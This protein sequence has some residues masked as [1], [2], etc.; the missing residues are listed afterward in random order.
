[1]SKLNKAIT[2]LI[3]VTMLVVLLAPAKMVWSGV[4]NQGTTYKGIIIKYK[5]DT[6]SETVK[7]NVKKKLKLKDLKSKKKLKKGKVEVVEVDEGADVTSIVNELRKDT[8]VLYAQP[9]YKLFL[10]YIPDEPDFSAQWG[11]NNTNTQGVD[12]GVTDAWDITKGSTDIIVGVLDTGIDISHDDL[13]KNIYVNKKEIAG[14]GKDDDQNGYIDD[15]NGWNFVSKNG[16]VFDSTI[17]DIHGTHVAGII[18]ASENKMGTIGVS[19]KVKLLPLKFINGDSGYTS[20]AIQAIEYAKAAGAKIINC[21]WGG[22]DENEVLKDEIRNNP[23]ILFIAAAGNGGKLGCAYPG[24]FNL[25]NVVSVGAVDRD[26]KL[27]AFSN[28]GPKVKLAAPG[29]NIL[30]T[31][32]GNNYGTLNGTSMSAPFV[33]G[34]S[35]LL[36]SQNKNLKP[37]EIAAML[38]NGSIEQRSLKGKIASGGIVNALSTLNSTTENKDESQQQDEQN[39]DTED[40]S[41]VEALA[42][43]QPLL[44][45]QIHF[46]KEGVY[47]PSGNFSDSYTDLAG[48]F[49]PFGE[50]KVTRTYNSLDGGYNLFGYGWSMGYY[51]RIEF[52]NSGSVLVAKVGGKSYAFLK[53]SYTGTFN[54]Y[55][56][57]CKMETQGETNNYTAYILTAQD[58]TKY[59]YDSYGFLS[60]IED[61]YGNRISFAN[62]STSNGYRI[63][64][65]YNSLGIEILITYNA[66]G[67][68]DTISDPMG[69]TVKY[70]YDSNSR[71]TCITNPMGNKT[72]YSY[73]TLNYYLSEIRNN[74]GD[75]LNKIEYDTSNRVCKITDAVKNTY[76][77]TYDPTNKK[78][79]VVDSNQNRYIYGYNDDK[80]IT[81]I[82]DPE[83]KNSGNEYNSYG[84]V[85]SATDRNGNITKYDRDVNGNITKI[86]N[87]DGSTK[88]CEYDDKNNLTKEV[89]EKGNT[90]YYF[91]TDK[92]YLAKKVQPM[93]STGLYSETGDQSRFAITTYT[94]NGYGQITS[95]KDPEGNVTTYDYDSKGYLISETS[96]EGNVTKYTNNPIGW[97]TKIIS[98]KGYSIDYTFDNN[99]AIIK[100]AASTGETRR[101][102]YNAAGR[103]VR[104]ISPNLY[105]P[106]NEDTTTNTYN[107]GEGSYITY[108][109]SGLVKSITDAENNT[110]SYTYDLYGQIET[111]SKGDGSVVKYEY[112]KLNRLYKVYFVSKRGATPILLREY[113]YEVLSDKN[114]KRTEKVYFNDKET[115]ETV[116]ILDYRNNVVEK[117]DAEGAATSTQYYSNG[118]ISSTKDEMGY[119]TYYRYDGIGRL[120]EKWSPF[121]EVKGTVYYSYTSI[122]YDKAGR[123]T[124]QR[125]SSEK[126][127]LYKVPGKIT[128]T[129]FTYDK[130]GNKKSQHTDSGRRT[131]F[132]YDADG[133]VNRET[134]YVDKT[135][136]ITTIYE[137]NQFGKT[138]KQKEYIEKRDLA[139]NDTGLK[140]DLQELVTSYEYDKEGNVVSVSKPDGT[141]NDYVHDKLGRQTS[142]VIYEVDEAGNEIIETTSTTYDFEGKKIS[143]TDANGYTTKYQYNRMG[144]LEKVIDPA[145]GIAA[146]YYDRAGRKT[147]EVSPANYYS[148]KAL[149][150]LNR[151]EYA[152]DK[153]GRIITKS[154]IYKNPVSGK[155]EKVVSKAYKYDS[156]GN[157]IKEVD[158]LGYLAG[159]GSTVDERIDKGYGTEYSYNAAGLK[160]S[161]LDPVS[162]ERE[163]DSTTKWE[164]DAKGQII[165]EISTDGAKDSNEYD[166]DGNIIFQKHTSPKTG[167]VSIIKSNTYDYL[168]NLLT[169]KDAKGNTTYY[170]YNNFG[171]KR[172]AKLPGDESIPSMEVYYQYDKQG[173]LS[174]EIYANSKVIIHK[175]NNKSLEVATTEQKLDESQAI[176]VSSVY[177]ANGN[178][179]IEKDGNGNEK[180]K[181]Y[182]ALNRL[183]SEKTIV[184]DVNRK[185]ITKITSYTYDKNGNQT[186][187]KDWKGN[188]LT[189]EYDPLNRLIK[190]TDQN[191]KVIESLYYYANSIQSKSTDALG[192]STSFWY[193]KNNR[194]V[195]KV[196][197][198]K[199]TTLQS[200]DN[201]GNI[202]SKTDGRGNVTKY[203]YDDFNRL[204]QVRNA[205]D[206]LT[207]YSYDANGNMTSIKDGKGNVETYEYNVANKIKRRID[208]GGKTGAVYNKAKT[209]VYTY[210]CYG[211]KA[212]VVDRNGIK[213][214][215]YYDIHGRL[216]KK[217][218]GKVFEENTLNQS[219]EKLTL[220]NVEVAFVE[221]SYDDNGNILTIEGAT[222]ITTRTY[223]EENRVTTK[224]VPQLGTS[225]YQYDATGK[226][227]PK[228]CHAEITTDPKGNVTCKT[229][230]KVGRLSAVTTGTQTTN[231]AY[232]DNGNRK[233]VTYP[234]GST[235]VYTY[236]GNNQIEALSNYRMS[237]GV[238]VLMD[239]YK[240]TYDKAGNQV[241]KN[242]IVNGVNKGVTAYTYDKLNR[243]ESVTDP[244]GKTIAYTFDAVGNRTTETVTITGTKTV[245]TY[246]Y[247]SENRLLTVR[248]KIND[249]ETA[250]VKYVYDGNGNMVSRSNVILD[251]NSTGDGSIS[252][253][254][255]GE[256]DNSTTYYE[257]DNFN[258]LVKVE[259][260]SKTQYYN[261]NGEGYRVEK[262]VAGKTTR[263]LYEGDKVVLEVDDDGL[264]TAR[265]VYG[266]NLLMRTIGSTTVY[267]MYN[268]HGD[269]TALLDASSSKIKA[270][271]SYDE[272]GNLKDNSKVD[273]E[274]EKDGNKDGKDDNWLY[275]A[276]ITAALVTNPAISGGKA[277]QIKTTASTASV[278]KTYATVAGHKYLFAGSYYIAS[279]GSSLST[280]VNSE[281]NSWNLNLGSVY[282]SSTLN[283][284]KEAGV[285]FTAT[286]TTTSLIPCFVDTQTCE[287]YIDKWKLIDLTELYGAG[288]E[289]TTVAAAMTDFDN[290]IMYAGYQYDKETG[291][292]YLNARMYDPTIARFLQEDTYTGEID[293][294]LSLNL[295]T[296]CY[297]EPIK[298]D[299]P[300][301]HFVR[302]TDNDR[303]EY[304][305]ENYGKNMSE[306]DVA[307]FDREGILHFDETKITDSFRETT[308][309]KQTVDSENNYK[310]RK[311]EKGTWVT[312][313][314]DAQKYQLD[315]ES[316]LYFL[317]HFA[318]VQAN[319]FRER[320][321]SYLR[322]ETKQNP[323]AYSDAEAYR[324]IANYSVKLNEAIINSDDQYKVGQVLDDLL[325]TIGSSKYSI[326]KNKYP[327][328]FLKN[329]DSKFQLGL[330]SFGQVGFSPDLQENFAND[331]DPNN[332]QHNLLAIYLGYNYKNLAYFP[333]AFHETIQPIFSG[334]QVSGTF[335][336]WESSVRGINLGKRLANNVPDKYK[337]YGAYTGGS[338]LPSGEKAKM[339]NL[340]NE[341]Y[342]I[343]TWV[344]PPPPSPKPAPAPIVTPKPK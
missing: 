112:D 343:I 4:G 34:I 216:V 65:I 157:V 70:Q 128:G 239:S 181:K 59:R 85:Y 279:K 200:Y 310:Y 3:L 246:S 38:S 206:E 213:T 158:A 198:L 91:Y 94:Y 36:K 80:Y 169:A 227:I 57:H 329:G 182:D 120:T 137:N 116:E 218:A 82:Q 222:G 230:D 183:I 68:I 163:L 241:T 247:N 207:S 253:A 144:L 295:Y 315:R 61:K 16:T 56:N 149:T 122:E 92:R 313:K 303:K 129:Y 293:D 338:S 344:K 142:T 42:T 271:Y 290:S 220:S 186:S 261:Y 100:E 323:T 252:A 214:S 156:R 278:Y 143:S 280:R 251:S 87:P 263:Y 90:T 109:P 31:I 119:S 285:V 39:E 141:K 67:Y 19:P 277:Q 89:D 240:Y 162:K 136:K 254:I 195:K 88:T 48:I 238:K 72:Y 316:R 327:N 289:P 341:I 159:T 262:T 93:S 130:D 229:F 320:M 25:S 197:S 133:N 178:K 237:G 44:T 161:V 27:A 309:Y 58:Q 256:N 211:N 123:V 311:D 266:T 308:L 265:N 177:D 135:N 75:S 55:G 324:K 11:L 64:K 43:A 179:V 302:V 283:Q 47:P 342:K 260:G 108:Y 62:S 212:S 106:E 270:A 5:D 150:D 2:R 20:D 52:Q 326:S 300:S 154:D 201:E 208:H 22:P 321:P 15:V 196:D 33:T 219:G 121:E 1:M 294:P 83:D 46:G 21:S 269:V 9:D 192:N 147:A 167:V 187:I 35:V 7:A 69:R 334:N 305:K 99:G 292:Y 86:T 140:E 191:G 45:E 228:G 236:N 339:S 95:Q 103:K 14:N 249:V 322:P 217:E 318:R 340:G 180:V 125:S 49:T 282:W 32:P 232:Y 333:A 29:V 264:R 336:D 23:D 331:P 194:L 8:N 127:L 77:F 71:L 146:Y 221:Y 17:F 204:I 51:G 284:W 210:D 272:W 111:E 107:G 114:T 10:N 337:T 78:T 53:D 312:I 170:E 132:E 267:Y 151:I 235:E 152:Y 275:S 330:R 134:V 124:A 243:L 286:G 244:S 63:D 288:N 28:Y 226:N 202:D 193:D 50:I 174:K 24:G 148:N 185:K 257:Y 281:G 102:V 205:K 335:E 325:L 245:N 30:S 255:S 96:P 145:G 6:K 317:K 304:I 189:M 101:F 215:F 203:V 54:P 13:S 301:G 74:D 118:A 98:P 268:G 306:D 37:A 40:S 18:G 307:L 314:F 171:Q 250:V 242:E 115:A 41:M 66:A 328:E 155:M 168:G 190:K 273:G 297:N 176:T 319:E 332:V 12:I 164:Y 79:T 287:V 104:E 175:Y 165:A 276:S 139:G 81:G 296:Y 76:T 234:D 184:T 173:R 113:K 73:S 233:S 298:Y 172:K 258:Q 225:R 166:S 224:T 131:E 26:G 274:F 299:D 248:T 291:L 126:V 231:I 84:E 160:T 199:N 105:E 223:D 110:K 117:I 209:E 259:A 138:V 153:T 97:T 188:K 60:H